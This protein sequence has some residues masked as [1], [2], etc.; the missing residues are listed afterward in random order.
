MSRMH[1]SRTD[2]SRTRVYTLPGRYSP[3]MSELNSA[4][5]GRVYLVV[6]RRGG[7]GSRRLISREM[8]IRSRMCARSRRACLRHIRQ[9]QKGGGGCEAKSN[10][11][12]RLIYSSNPRSTPVRSLDRISGTLVM[13]RFGRQR[14]S[15]VIN[16]LTRSTESRTSYSLARFLPRAS[17]LALALRFSF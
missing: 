11:A 4:D 17:L 13:P 16:L 2:T 5:S 12:R 15:R 1:D 10:G 3:A 7:Q 6:A 9:E 8:N 14:D